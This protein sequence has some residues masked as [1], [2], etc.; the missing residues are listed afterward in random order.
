LR[1]WRSTVK[2]G[3][4]IFRPLIPSWRFFDDV[5]DSV[6]L[7]YRVSQ[8]GKSFDGW[9]PCPNRTEKRSWLELFLNPEQNYRLACHSL[10]VRFAEGDSVSK[11]LIENLI[12]AQTEASHYQFKILLNDTE[13]FLSP[14]LNREKTKK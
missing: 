7:W 13:L 5:S 6:A 11:D 10:I 4:M 1:S 12:S 14:V 3:E 8:D 2:L 9:K